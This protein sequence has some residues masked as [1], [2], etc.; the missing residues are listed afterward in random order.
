MP[1]VGNHNGTLR[2]FDS[3]IKEHMADRP[4]QFFHSLMLNDRGLDDAIA[5]RQLTQLI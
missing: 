2:A 3:F 1:G 4:A 5:S